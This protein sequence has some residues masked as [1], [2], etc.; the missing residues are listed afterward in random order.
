MPGERGGADRAQNET[1]SGLGSSDPPDITRATSWKWSAGVAPVATPAPSPGTWVSAI[2]IRPA[3]GE[4]AIGGG[5]AKLSPPVT[6][7]GLDTI[8]FAA[9]PAPQLHAGD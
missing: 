8:L 3:T 2:K 7:Q 5:P 9:S 6:F 4:R 1:D